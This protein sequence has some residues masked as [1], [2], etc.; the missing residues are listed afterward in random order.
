MR[1]I[2]L[3]ALALCLTSVLSFSQQ[4]KAKRPS[5][6][7]SA[8]CK[9][10]DGTTIT[11]DYSSPRAKGRKIFGGLVPLGQVWR[12]GANDA[13]TF[14]TS[15]NVKVGGTSVPKGRYTLYTLP[16][17]NVWQLIVNKQTGQWGTEYDQKQDFARIEMKSEALP[18]AVENFTIALD[19]NT[20]KSCKLRM[21]W[22]NTRA[23][24]DI[25]EAK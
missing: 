15:G 20:G 25:T 1:K 14:V 2:L 23:S 21:D 16:G 10:A 24:V 3:V 6:P 13:T 7:A 17:D 4:D 12:T 19:G 5:P 11:I 9:F 22:E 18:T 8:S